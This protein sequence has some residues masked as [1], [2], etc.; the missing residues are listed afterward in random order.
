MLS[1]KQPYGSV[2]GQVVTERGPGKVGAAPLAG[3][4][5][6]DRSTATAAS[7]VSANAPATRPRRLLPDIPFISLP[8]PAERPVSG[9]LE[10]VRAQALCTP[11]GR[12]RLPIPQLRGRL[13][14]ALHR[15]FGAHRQHRWEHRGGC[16]FL[17]TAG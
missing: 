4:A 2:H 1:A 7:M 6:K 9:P 15:R 12:V 13:P 3:A 10:A 5:V 11:P 8:V 17:L 14:P 16:R